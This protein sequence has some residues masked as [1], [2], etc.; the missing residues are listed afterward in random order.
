MLR[1]DVPASL[2]AAHRV[3]AFVMATAAIPVYLLARRIGVRL[4]R[5]SESRSSMSS[6]MRDAP[7][8]RCR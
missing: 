7:G 3:N 8:Y 6:P 2:E 5:D 1:A 4:T